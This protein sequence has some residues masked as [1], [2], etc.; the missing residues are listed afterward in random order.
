MEETYMKKEPLNDMDEER[1]VFSIL[2]PTWKNLPFLKLCVES[3]LKHSKFRHQIIIH[4]NDGS[5]GTLEW[6]K[7]RGFDYTWSEENIG[8][9]LAM[10]MMRTKVKTEYMLF[11]N[12]DMYV[13][14][15]WDTALADEIDR[16]PDKR[17]FLSSTTIQA[18][19]VA[20]PVI[21]ADYGHTLEEFRRDDLLS[22]YDSY[23]FDDWM[24]ATLPPNI[25]HRD[26]W[27]L[28]GGY[29]V[30]YSPGMYSD[31]DFTAKLWF[32]GV[33]YMK[34]IS[35]SRVYHFET[36]T[37]TR[38][39]RN[40]GRMQFLLKWG[41]T[42]ASFRRI[43]THTDLKGFD[44]TTFKSYSKAKDRNNRLRCR[45]LAIKGVISK[46]CGPVWR[47]GSKSPADDR[48]EF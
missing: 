47:F 9:C 42:A 43:F 24:G 32:C 14:P 35:A 20:G 23:K 16:L 4:V 36:K 7:S 10:N 41:A 44:A 2:I 37:T 26:I 5:D 11:I 18:H 17:F 8:V 38:I 39:K 15:G 27:D 46:G 30:E 40:D 19:P 12:D 31:P 45:L 33:R 1:P 48:Y 22:E 29:S 34:G 13:L 25:V 21:L 28:V 6:V 3:I